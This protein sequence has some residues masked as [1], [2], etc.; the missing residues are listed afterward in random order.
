M[1][2][3]KQLQ[4]QE[5]KAR[6]EEVKASEDSAD[7]ICDSIQKQLDM[8][9]DSDELFKLYKQIF[10]EQDGKV[11]DFFN[12]NDYKMLQTLISNY[13]KQKA[14]IGDVL[15]LKDFVRSQNQDVQ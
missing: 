8:S 10:G 4:P 15:E 2:Q 14:I 1:E 3:Q 12:T 5:S 6:V 9:E 7:L 11:I 13:L